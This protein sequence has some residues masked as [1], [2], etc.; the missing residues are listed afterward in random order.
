[1]RALIKTFSSSRTT[2]GQVMKPGLQIKSLSP[3]ELLIKHRF[4]SISLIPSRLFHHLLFVIQ[5]THF[6]SFIYFY[7]CPKASKH[8]TSIYFIMTKIPHSVQ[9]THSHPAHLS[10][11][12]SLNV[13]KQRGALSLYV[14]PSPKRRGGRK[15]KAVIISY[16]VQ[17]TTTRSRTMIQETVRLNQKERIVIINK[18][19]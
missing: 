18:V 3:S 8:L 7:S 12:I 1:M 15:Q 10:F 17:Q 4:I 6:T 2:V 13:R 14:C 9:T 11:Y 16:Q 19:K 5:A